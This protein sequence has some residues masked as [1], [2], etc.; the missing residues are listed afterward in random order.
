[1]NKHAFSQDW[2]AQRGKQYIDRNFDRM[3]LDPS[4]RQQLF[5]SIGASRK[6][7]GFW[8]RINPFARMRRAATSD[9]RVQQHA[10][11][12]MRS[13]LRDPQFVEQLFGR[14]QGFGEALTGTM[15]PLGLAG[16]GAV[17]GGGIAAATGRR[18]LALG[19]GIGGLGALGGQVA[20]QARFASD[21]GSWAKAFG[22]QADPAARQRLHS[23]ATMYS[24]FTPNPAQNKTASAVEIKGFRFVRDR[25][26]ALRLVNR[27]RKDEED[28]RHGP[29]TIEDVLQDLRGSVTPPVSVPR[30][31]MPLGIELAMGLGAD[32]AGV[33]PPSWGPST[34]RLKLSFHAARVNS[35]STDFGADRTTE[36]SRMLQQHFPLRHALR[37]IGRDPNISLEDKG[38]IIGPMLNL[39]PGAKPRAVTFRDALPSLI[40]AGVG[41]A[42][43]S[44]VGSLLNLAPSQRRAARIGGAM[45]GGVLNNPR[46]F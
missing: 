38:R 33:R 15:G 27:P 42:G 39:S 34:G 21:P 17:A 35:S 22:S 23:L 10:V 13:R 18:G 30:Y 20:R 2:L 41:Y 7:P 9:P 36:A 37:T 8:S 5:D 3:M 1:M 45:V 11:S 46:I 40:G 25:D 16:A 12:T 43:A 31:H 44:A 6:K 19:A 28:D 14:R 4:R 29:R 26:G 24:T 32:A